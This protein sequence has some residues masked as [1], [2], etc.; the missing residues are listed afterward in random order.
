MKKQETPAQP[1]VVPAAVADFLT[2][3]PGSALF[4]FPYAQSDNFL[5][6]L[7]TAETPLN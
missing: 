6:P 4:S 7:Q 5:R 1:Q 3:P 2:R